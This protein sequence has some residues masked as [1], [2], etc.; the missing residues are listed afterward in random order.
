M[1][2]CKF[3]YRELNKFDQIVKGELRAKN[4]L[5]RQGNEKGGTG[6]TSLKDVYEE[7]ALRVVC[8]MN[9]FINRWIQ[10]ASRREILKE[11]NAIGKKSTATMVQ[12]VVKLRF[13]NNTIQLEDQLIEREQKPT[14]KKLK[15]FL[16]KGIELKR[17]ELF[18]L[19]KKEQKI[20]Q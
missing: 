10:A 15:T 13:G 20:F 2:I 11:E 1:K 9:K 5:R 6:L 16:K 17:T 18:Q 4:M 19:K 8:Y 12:V 3:S 7:T 14:W